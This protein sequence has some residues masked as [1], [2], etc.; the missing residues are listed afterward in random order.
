MDAPQSIG[1]RAGE[2]SW[3]SSEATRRSMR[4]NTGRD[5]GPELRLRSEVHRLGLRFRVNIRPLPRVR[6]TADLVFTRQKVAVFLDGCFWHGCPEHYSEPATNAE[7]WANK[8]A[9]NAARDRETDCL[10]RRAGWIVLRV[11][12]HENPVEAALA[13]RTAVAAACRAGSD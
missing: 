12:E 5:T 3:A 2:A 8:V 11:W 13:V 4:S 6:R 7:Y 1:S 9:A 10:L